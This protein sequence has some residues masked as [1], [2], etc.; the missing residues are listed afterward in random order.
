MRSFTEN[1][2]IIRQIME[3]KE[4]PTL[5]DNSRGIHGVTEEEQSEMEEEN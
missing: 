4:T 2:M 3:P 1:K 5:K